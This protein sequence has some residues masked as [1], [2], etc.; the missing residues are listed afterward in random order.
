[1]LKLSMWMISF[2]MK[3]AFH[4]LKLK[5]KSIECVVFTI[6]R[7][8]FK[9]PRLSFGWCNS[10]PVFIKFM[11]PLVCFLHA[12]QSAINLLPPWRFGDML[13]GKHHPSSEPLHRRLLGAPSI[14]HYSP[15]VVRASSASAGCPPSD[16]QTD[17]EHLDTNPSPLAPRSIPRHSL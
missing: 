13:G 17:Q 10:L 6:N 11:R 5:E 7:E 14:F 3:N 2:D 9:A 16:H 1:M 15:P 12:P 8:T 4:H